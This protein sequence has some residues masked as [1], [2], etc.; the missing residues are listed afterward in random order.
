MAPKPFVL[1][2]RRD[3]GEA[4]PQATWPRGILRRTINEHDAKA[5]HA[6]L[7]AGYWEGG[8]GAP[9]FRQWWSKLSKDRHFDPELCFLA[10]D[11]EGVCGICQCWTSNFIKDLAVHPRARRFGIGRALMLTAFAA[12][13]MRGAEFVELKV[14]E[15]NPG[16]QALYKELGMRVIAR[17]RG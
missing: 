1:R 12:F 6:V 9:K 14:R 13:K 5:A 4:I 2:M 10:T 15:E 16:A 11:I 17:E 7:E 8:G 3:L